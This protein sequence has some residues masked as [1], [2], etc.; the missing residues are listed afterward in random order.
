M[1]SLKNAGYYFK[2]RLRGKGVYIYYAL[3][4]VEFFVTL[5]KTFF[6]IKSYISAYCFN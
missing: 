6:L 3:V 5:K 1:E 2:T 4:N